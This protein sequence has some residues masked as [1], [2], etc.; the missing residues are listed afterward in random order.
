MKD[1]DC[2]TCLYARTPDDPYNNG[3]TAWDCDYINRK[4]AIEAWK[5][6]RW[7]PCEKE[8]PKDIG[9]YLT[10]IKYDHSDGYFCMLL[11][12]YDGWNCFKENKE[13]EIEGVVAWMPLPE[14]YNGGE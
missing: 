6:T 10:S 4:E 12:W 13:N 8:L 1:R 9:Y 14:Q 11:H 3:C 7:I 5:R 2:K